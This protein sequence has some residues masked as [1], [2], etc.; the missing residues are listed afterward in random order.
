MKYKTLLLLLLCVVF[1]SGYKY[2]HNVPPIDGTNNATERNSRGIMYMEMG[3]YAA[4]MSE[5]QIAISLSPDAPTSSAYYNNLGLLMLKLN[6][7]ND[8]KDCFKKAIDRNPVFLEYYKNLITASGQA[9][10]LNSDLNMYLSQI[11]SDNNNSQAYFM[12]G[13][14]Y[15]EKGQKVLAVQYLKRFTKLEKVNF[16]S[17][18]ANNMIKELEK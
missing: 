3:Q 8:A 17:G 15:A 11:A 1:L 16:L 9:G 18:A 7:A 4:A 13:L 14:I 5:F 2:K 10:S 12:A 6:R